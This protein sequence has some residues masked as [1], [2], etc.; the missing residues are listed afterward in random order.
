VSR[1]S[2]ARRGRRTLTVPLNVLLVEDDADDAEMIARAL[3]CGGW[4]VVVDA[5]K[6]DRSFV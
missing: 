5:L 1:E 6:I 4:K 3:R 2:I